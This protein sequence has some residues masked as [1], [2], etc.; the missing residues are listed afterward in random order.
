MFERFTT[1]AR[2][3][4]VAA[5]ADAESRG[6]QRVT[7]EHLLSAVVDQG[8]VAGQVLLGAGLSRSILDEALGIDRAALDYL[9]IDLEQVLART[10]AHFPD[11]TGR[12]PLYGVRFAAESKKSL[13]LALREAIRLSHRHIGSEHILLGILRDQENRA[14]RLMIK[15]DVS[16]ASLRAAI[17]NKLRAAG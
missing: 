2:E 1:E 17:E 12:S 15:R 16:P 3:I 10:R 5:K 14:C 11:Q 13:E 8:G 6:H 9:G 7:T 4:V